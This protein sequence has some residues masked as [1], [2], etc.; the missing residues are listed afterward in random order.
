MSKHSH[1]TLIE[2]A[3]KTANA[4]ARVANKVM[5]ASIPIPVP[6][7]FNLQDVKPRAAGLAYYTMK[8][9]LNMILF[10]DNVE[11]MLN[12]TIPHEIG[13]LVQFNKF[14]HSGVKTQGHGA[15]WQE[16]MRRLGKSPHKFHS[17]NT[18]R[19]ISHYKDLQ[20]A[21]RKIAK[22]KGGS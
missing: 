18:S 12:E 6:I 17:L 7:E 9:N 19:A 13:H 14:D 4:Y 22:L 10:E 5:G 2:A 15:E 11:Y 3:Q 1:Q 20:K 21:K 16:V 8:I